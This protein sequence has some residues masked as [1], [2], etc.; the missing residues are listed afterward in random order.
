[1]SRAEKYFI[2]PSALAINK[3]RQDHLASL[4]LELENKRVLEVGAGIGLHTPFFIDRGCKIVITDGNPENVEKIKSRHPDYQ[5]LVLDLEQ[6]SSLEHLGTFDLVYSY[7]LFYHLANVDL[8]VQRL[9]EICHGQIL[10]ETRV[11]VKTDDSIDYMN[12]HGGNNGSIVGKASR[13]SR[14]WMLNCLT[15]H[16]GHSY[17]AVTQPKHSDFP[18][19]W[20]QARGNDNRAIFVGSKQSLNLTTLSTVLLDQQKIYQT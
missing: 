8:A 10:V 7:G 19:N 12:D 3:A 9:A 5:S 6:E 2:N 18:G 14:Q 20:S 15:K 1:M 17:I 4:G 16:F 11:S 13:P